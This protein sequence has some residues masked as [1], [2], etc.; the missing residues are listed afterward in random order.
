M[1]HL[2]DFLVFY[3]LKRI[4]FLSCQFVVKDSGD[5]SVHLADP[6]L[7]VEWDK[8]EEIH[9]D[10]QDSH[11]CP[12]C[13][14][15]PQA[16]RM[17]K[18][19]HIY[20]WSCILHYLSLSDKPWR[21]CPICYESIYKK[22]LKSV[23]INNILK[24][25][26]T[27]DQI[28][29][30]LMFKLKSKYNSITLPVQLYE[31]FMNDEEQANHFSYNIFNSD[32]YCEY[33]QFLKIQ[34]KSADYILNEVLKREKCELQT[35]ALL[36]KDQ[37]EVCFVHEA[38]KLLEER[39][40]ELNCDILSLKRDITENKTREENEKFPKSP[41]LLM[42]Q[43]PDLIYQDAF[44][45]ITT[46]YL[47]EVEPIIGSI[48]SIEISEKNCQINSEKSHDQTA[49]PLNSSCKKLNNQASNSNQDNIYFYQSTDGQRIYI[50]ALNIRCLMTEFGSF[51]S[52]PS[53]IRAKIVSCDSYFMTEENRKRF[54]YLAHLPLH[55]EF[56]I[57]E[58]ELKEPLLS[59]NTLDLFEEEFEER[60][61]FR[62][63][64]E[65]R[66]KRHA[67]RIAANDAAMIVPQYSVQSAMEEIKIS[68]I[69]MD[70]SNQFPEASSSPPASSGA[71]ISGNSS[72]GYSSNDG[73]NQQQSQQP[74]SFAQM[75]RNP[76]GVSTKPSKLAASQSLPLNSWPSLDEKPSPGLPK[77][78]TNQLTSGWLNMA[79][80]HQ[81][82]SPSLGRT[83]KYQDPP[84]PLSNSVKTNSK[85]DSKAEAIDDDDNQMSAPVYSKSFFSAIDESL[86]MI[87][88]SIKHIL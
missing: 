75:L 8:I 13:L 10:T 70:Y 55:S 81:E 31:Q 47:V 57:A 79:K 69:L 59:K 16:G 48:K 68:D 66:E 4:L 44:E 24:D 82:Q 17:T 14:Y 9:L 22:D 33:K 35:Q 6:D 87:E 63:R 46:D 38:I 3:S 43:R 7:L 64:K 19:G 20:C 78:T 50:N 39:E 72:S 73:N 61:Q 58:L 74:I 12:I 5:Y 29:L 51:E 88:T 45:N 27:G 80:L 25:F 67:D 23:K 83:K 86:K 26:K 15:P 11:T 76:N 85:E 71:S 62:L 28:E 42:D 34:C 30:N 21:K 60:R 18:C 40:H 41:I 56:K 32:L 36:E 77:N 1:N 49:E 52:C 53:K 84:K 65:K 37:P 2:I 54:K